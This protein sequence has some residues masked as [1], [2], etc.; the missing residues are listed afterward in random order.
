[1]DMPPEKSTEKST[2]FDPYA[3]LITLPRLMPPAVVT[4][5]KSTISPGLAAV[6]AWALPGLGYWLIGQRG[7]GVIVCVSVISLFVL[8]L[9]IGGVRVLEV[10]AER[11]RSGLCAS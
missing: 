1:M 5:P 10:P 4:R 6:A 2:P 9:L 11:I 3:L 8:G 7:R